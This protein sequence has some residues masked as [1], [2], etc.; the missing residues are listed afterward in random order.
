[1][2]FNLLDWS[3]IAGYLLI[4]LLLGLY[5]RRRSARS[6]DDY[7][8]SGR[9]VSWWLAGTSMVATTFAADTPLVVS[10]IVY[11]QGIAGNWLWWS[12]LL[13]GMMTV[14]LFAR[15]WRRSG[16]LTD[17]QFAEMRYSGKPAAFLRGFRAV[18]LGLLMNCLILGWVTKAM[19]TIVAATLGT[20][21]HRALAICIFFLIPF[22]GFYVALGGLWGVLWTDLFQFVLKMSIVIAVAYYAVEAAGGMTAL[23]DKLGA[24]RAAAGPAAANATAFLPDFSRGFA[25]Q[26]LWTYPVIT[27]AVNLGLQ[28]WAFW[29]PGAEPG[30]G[31]YIAQRIFSAR[32]ERHGLLSVLWFNVA[33]YAVR[34]WPW[35]ITGL[36]AIVLYPGLQKPEAGYMLVLN[37]H[38][39][40]ALRGIAIAGF[41]AAF[42]STVATQLN[43]GASYLVADFYRRFLKRDRSEAHYVKVSRL[44]TVVLVIASAWVSAQLAS[45]G[46]GWQIVLEVGAGT[47]GVYL[48]RWY[49]WR[50]NAWSEISA[51]ISAMTVSLLLSW[52]GLWRMLTTGARTTAFS[53]SSPV[54]FAKAALTT[55]VITT[56]VWVAVTLL[57][58]PEPEDVLLRFYR[59]VRPD[60]RGWTP[61]AKLAPDASHT[62]DL[63]PNLR[64]WVLGCAMV[65]LALFGTGKLVLKDPGLGAALLAVAVLCAWLLYR[66]ISLRWAQERPQDV[67]AGQVTAGSQHSSS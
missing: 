29:Y 38:L 15:L 67:V 31:G 40:H 65:Y 50:I 62:R 36:A 19:T 28:W 48:L 45:I 47:G 21:E 18:Y 60:S 37:H 53:G 25:I 3:A 63:G 44:A 42:M 1:M 46:S 57:T 43:W 10:G 2:K 26:P 20:S 5:F 66:E 22:T 16:L 34:P 58:A 61:I 52:G 6:V 12:F 33:H 54:V 59:K 41:L 14:F 49:W 30:G 7:F 13:S 23:L 11:T 8:V 17:V 55:T 9:N 32:D 51:M 64:A 27:F 24:M 4:T 56:V 35:V 39:P